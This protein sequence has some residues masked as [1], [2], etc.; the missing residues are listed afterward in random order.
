MGALL[1]AV[2]KSIYYL[3]NQN[4]VRLLSQGTGR[5]LDR[6]KIRAL[7]YPAVHTEPAKPCENLDASPY[8]V[9]SEQN[10]NIEQFRV[11]EMYGQ[12][13]HTWVRLGNKWV[14]KLI[15]SLVSFLLLSPELLI[16]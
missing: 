8:K 6:L 11:N 7:R 10:E 9:P 4:I 3:K 5:I 2:A 13:F 12:I 14:L 16:N 1:L 15:S